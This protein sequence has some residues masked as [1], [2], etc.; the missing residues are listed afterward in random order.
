LQNTKGSDRQ[1]K[2]D[3]SLYSLDSSDKKLISMSNNELDKCKVI[4]DQMLSL[5]YG[6]QM[7]M[8]IDMLFD[9]AIDE[10]WTEN[11]I[12]DAVK[13]LIKTFPYPDWKIANI[14]GY[15]KKLYTYSGM[16]ELCKKGRFGNEFIR[17]EKND[18]IYFWDKQNGNLPKFLIERSLDKP[19]RIIIDNEQ[20]KRSESIFED[21]FT[22]KLLNEGWVK[23]I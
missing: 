9:M 10:G 6:D 22:E 13:Y 17:C 3:I 7:S 2:N 12:I 5:A 23:R 16:M 19:L 18:N 11:Q 4:L 21:E 8:K 15:D 20:L 1:N 14:L